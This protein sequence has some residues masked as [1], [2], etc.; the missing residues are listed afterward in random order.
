MDFFELI[1]LSKKEKEGKKRKPFSLFGG[2]RGDSC[3]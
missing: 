1:G 3:F 2:G